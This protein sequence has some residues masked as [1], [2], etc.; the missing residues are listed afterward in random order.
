MTNLVS[1]GIPL[2]DCHE[3]LPPIHNKEAKGIYVASRASI[4]ERSAMWREHRGLGWNIISTWIDEAGEGE[5]DSFE[6]LW[7]R[8]RNEIYACEYFILYA[9]RDDFPLKG[10]LVEV[11]MA[12]AFQKPVIIV[13]NFEPEGRT[14]RPIGSWITHPYVHRVDTIQHALDM[15]IG[16]TTHP[17]YE[18]WEVSENIVRDMDEDIRL[19]AE[20]LAK[21]SVACGES[22]YGEVIHKNN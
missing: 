10:A 20:Q 12:L 11:G 2:F 5:T 21:D 15:A 14:Y 18:P 13:L 7:L 4:P 16:L 6:D 1:P 19:W 3:Y 9:E 8:I 22:E 17:I